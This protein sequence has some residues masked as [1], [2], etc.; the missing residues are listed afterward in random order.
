MNPHA[1]PAVGEMANDPVVRTALED[2]WVASRPDDPDSR[3]EE[4][5]WIYFDPST[6]VYHVRLAAAGGRADLDLSGP[7][8]VPGAFLVA[9]FHTHPNPAAE[10]WQTGP[11]RSDTDSAWE[12][13]VPCIIRAEDGIHTTGPDSRRGGLTGHPGFPD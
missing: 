1:A 5:G 4:G 12:L 3:H 9:T 10:G 13:G 11:S 8:L 7:P 2:A 6:A